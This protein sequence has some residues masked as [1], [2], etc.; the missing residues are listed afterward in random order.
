MLFFGASAYN[1]PQLLI[2]VTGESNSGAEGC[3][4]T[5]L[6]A[7]DL[8]PRQ[9]VQII[10]NTTLIFED[11]HIG[12][13]DNL[14]HYGLSDNIV[15]GIE[16]FVCTAVEARTLRPNP[17]YV[18]KTGQGGSRI[19]QW[20]VDD[21]SGY[22]TTFQNRIAAAQSALSGMRYRTV[23]FYSQ[24]INDI[25][26]STPT[27]TWKTKTIDHLAKIRAVLGPETLVAMTKFMPPMTA[28][29][30]NST[31]DEIVSSDPYTFAIDTTG[32]ELYNSY[33]WNDVGFQNVVSPGFLAIL[34]NH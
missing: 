22:W 24:G 34:A 5:V 26:A 9:S 33:H 3:R 21:V 27:A 18:V 1:N 19:A 2:V 25:V 16:H 12:V 14:G 10:N 8:L 29:G 23:V 28:T 31:I 6:S 17:A 11:L 4:N 7:N 30:Y 15:H 13:N 20:D 32:A